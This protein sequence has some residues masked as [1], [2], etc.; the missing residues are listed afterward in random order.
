MRDETP[1]KAAAAI[2]PVTNLV[3]RL[4]YKGPR[5]QRSFATQAGI[6]GLPHEKPDEYIKRS[7]LYQVEKLQVPI[8]VHVATN[9]L[10][11]NY[12]E[13]EQMVW[14]L[15][16]LKPDLAETKIY[17]DPAPWGSSAGHAFSRRVDP[18]T[19]ERVDSPEQ[20]D[21]WNR[22]WTFFDWILRPYQDKSK[23]AA[24]TNQ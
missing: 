17:V 9:D 19:L 1:F 14:K 23:P 15:R 21:S 3:F 16:A 11:V 6:G 10:D 22:T 7:P 12:V 20:I 13:D 8:L 2:V 24:A 4:G 18:E 5:Y